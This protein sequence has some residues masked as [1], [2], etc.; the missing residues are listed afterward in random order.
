M[1]LRRIWNAECLS[2]HL[3]Y[4]LHKF[5]DEDPFGQCTREGE[6][7]YISKSEKA[8]AALL[9]QYAGPPFLG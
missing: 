1:A 3:T 8:M 2:W 4:L 6:V 9:E 7:M 5:P